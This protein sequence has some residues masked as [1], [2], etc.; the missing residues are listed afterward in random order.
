MT[1]LGFIGLGTMGQPMALNLRQAGHPLTVFARNLAR[2]EPLIRA[3]AH[4]A[5]SPKGVAQAADI[6]F[7]NVADDEALEA[8]LFGPDGVAEGLGQ[9]AVVVDMGTTSPDATRD[10]AG[11]LAGQGTAML[12]A[13]VSG[14]E[15]GARAGTLSIMA[16]GPEAAFRR[17][18]PL[19]QVM[20]GNIV[21]VGGT[22]AGQVAK[23]CNQIA[24]S[25]SLLGVAEALAFA[26]RQGVDAGKVRQA[27]LGGSAYSRILEIHGQRMLE[28][29]FAP[30]FK[31][32]LHQKDLG[33]VLAE[34]RRLG[35]AL[36]GAAMAAQLINALVGSGGGEADSSALIQ[37][38]E[39]LN[40]AGK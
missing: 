8:V 23:A 35:L 1:S 36:P 34:A 20:G 38:L 14:G 37:V 28:R 6:V 18:L 32:R 31:A 7:V 13:P 21:H 10:F 12:D 15:A 3:G 29:N 9:N 24:V 33:I 22:G 26:A 30:G 40:G 17:V 11:R 39:Q 27:L 5:V 19:F 25:A 16:G 4:A 2:A